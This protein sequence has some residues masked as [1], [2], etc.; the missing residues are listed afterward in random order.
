M[1]AERSSPIF[2]DGKDGSV[3]DA[4]DEGSVTFCVKKEEGV[5]FQRTE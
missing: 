5:S 4:S 3:R 2:F 1:N